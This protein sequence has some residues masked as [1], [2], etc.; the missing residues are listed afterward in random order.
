MAD[1]LRR[2]RRR[3]P[4][5]PGLRREA[6]GLQDRLH[7]PQHL[8]RY[9]VHQP[10][11]G[12]V[13]D[14][15]TEL[16][17]ATRRPSRS[18]VVAAAARA[19]DRL[20]LRAHAARR[21]EPG[22]SCRTAWTAAHGFEIVHTHYEGW[23]SPRPTHGWPTLRCTGACVGPRVPLRAND[24]PA[25]D[26]AAPQVELLCDCRVVDRG[27]GR[28]GALDGPLRPERDGR[29]HS[30]VDSAWATW[31][32]PALIIDAWLLQSGQTLTNAW[33]MTTRLRR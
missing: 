16:L 29:A 18:G 33:L 23:R 31:S 14:T 19:R 10:I 32:P 12:P 15:T 13:W 17:A 11:W 28:G 25:E 5:A 6:A 8:A 22:R 3:A 24:Q 30:L 1:R 20:R 2:G 7:Q 27:R 9:G 4:D 26:P 21:H